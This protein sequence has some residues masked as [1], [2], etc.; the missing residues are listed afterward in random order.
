MRRF[1]LLFP[2]ILSLWLAW[3]GAAPADAAGRQ[4]LTIATAGGTRTFSVELAKTGPELDRGLMHRRSLPAG[5]GMLF[6][7][8]SVQPVTM[9]MKNTYVPLDMLFIGA[10]G[11]V[12]RIAANTKPLSTALIPGGDGVRYVLEV[13]AGTA[14]KLGIAPGDRVSHPAIVLKGQ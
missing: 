14:R 4:S 6:D 11:R 9:W 2:A 10:D 1:G 7:F 13:R 8:G 12:R 5:R 3:G